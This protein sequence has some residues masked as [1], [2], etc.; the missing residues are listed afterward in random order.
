ML[1][2]RPA[3]VFRIADRGTL[4]V[5]APAD[6]LVID[7]QTVHAG[8]L[9]RIYDQPAGQDR[10]I[11]QAT[12]IDA[13]VVNGVLLRQ[14]GIDQIDITGKLPGKLLRGGRAA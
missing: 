13:V 14:H 8:K 11:V 3:E 6:V 7:P 9:E 5:G 1:T 12:G 4:K 10:L 2:S